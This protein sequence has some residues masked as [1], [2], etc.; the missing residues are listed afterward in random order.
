MPVFKINHTILG[1]LL[2]LAFVLVAASAQARE[3]TQQFLELYEGLLRS[4]VQSVTQSEIPFAGVDY[5]T[6]GE[7]ERH[8]RALEHLLA[9]GPSP[10]GSKEEQMAY[11]IN[12][13]N[14]L[15]VDLIIRE[16]ER[17]SIRNLGG[18]FSSP[19]T[20][21]SWAI[22]GRDYTLDFIEHDILR[23]MGDPRIHFAINCASISC[24]DLRSESYDAERLNEQLGDQVRETLA[25]TG[26]GLFRDGNKIYVSKIFDWFAEDFDSGDV[27]GW[28]R[29][30]ADTPDQFSLRYLKYDWALN[31]VP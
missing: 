18:L 16:N 2:G 10:E 14:F 6:W 5:D 28:V 19:W 8:N 21:F 15:T 31:I 25:N 30:Y 3:E 12:A 24:P 9:Q 27:E 4:H 1:R 7:D 11:W 23:L 13:Y 22:E 17:E 20:K 29:R 26:K